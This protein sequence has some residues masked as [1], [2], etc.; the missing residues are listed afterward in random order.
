MS[1]V[2]LPWGWSGAQNTA[3]TPGEL[4]KCDS[5]QAGEQVEDSVSLSGSEGLPQHPSRDGRLQVSF[6]L[7]CPRRDPHCNWWV[8]VIAIALINAGSLCLHCSADIP[9]PFQAHHQLLF[10]EMGGSPGGN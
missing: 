9:K 5:V 10:C 3:Q 2:S 8:F 1:C 7:S 4:H 6:L